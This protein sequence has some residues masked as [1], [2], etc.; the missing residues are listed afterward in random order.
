MK[1]ITPESLYDLI[2]LGDVQLS[3]DGTLAVF[4]RQTVDAATNGYKRNIWIK[5]L[6]SDLPAEPFTSGNK[7]G[8]P[9]FSPDGSRLAF[10]SARGDKAQVYVLQ[11]RGG[12]AHSIVAHSNGVGGF[13]WSPD[14][15][16]IAYTASG[17]ADERAREDGGEAWSVERGASDVAPVGKDPFVAKQEKEKYEHEEQLR[18]DPRTLRRMPYRTG[19]S[20]MEDKWAHIYVSEVPSDFSDDAVAS[21]KPGTPVRVTDGEDS[22]DQPS[23]LRDG[24]A[25]ISAFT[26][27]IEG[28]RWYMYTDV[29]RIEWAKAA[30]APTQRTLTRLTQPGYSCYSPKVSPDGQWIAYE[31]SLEDRPGHR[32]Q[33]IALLPADA[34]TADVEP[35]DL[36]SAL[37][38]SVETVKWHPNSQHIY[39]TLL[40]DGNV[41]LWRV[42][43]SD[44]KIEPLTALNHDI[45]SF[46]VDP[47]GRVVFTAGTAQDPSALYAREVD[48]I[49]HILYK[50]NRKFLEAHEL[51]E[52]ERI[53]YPSDDHVI[54]GWVMKPPNYESGT[55]YSLVVEIHG[56]PH[57]QW[58][59]NFP[60]MF[61]E[62]QTLAHQGYI[63]FFC[64]PRGADGY[65]EAFMGAN[66]KDW[67]PGPT[68][69]VL[70]GVDELI[71]RGDIDVERMAVT[72]GSY[73][74]YLT[75]WI[76]GHD[77]R[78]KAAVSQ[79]GVY[80]LISMR[81]TTDIPFFNDF[82][83]GFTPWENINS[84]WEQSPLAHVPNMHTPLLIEH[85][86]Q[87]YRVPMEQAEQLFQAL[88]LLKKP[89]EFLRWPR[90][91]H[92]L[93]RSGEPRHRVQRLQRM[94]EWFDRYTKQIMSQAS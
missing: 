30:E 53:Q 71:A 77:Q 51:G 91:G 62:W 31:R 10:I 6:Q 90:E 41:N 42:S 73:G 15:K 65:G 69:D 45:T 19:T 85:S 13:E 16:R 94:I 79:R 68:R 43:V 26:R 74:G 80:N 11:M 70:R 54:E 84:L 72:G 76:I 56:G 52:I 82:E 49:V 29:V 37:D 33:S 57:V 89:V 4:V 1:S 61:H 9:R 83:S 81:G 93:S 25:L 27:E 22:F 67:G 44:K 35:I 2:N 12:E 28:P 24:S 3:S 58:T 64:N 47:T 5:D 23:W 40:K 18:F 59:P 60:S 14:G 78:F 34:R 48:G 36:T 86:E 20:F 32:I 38:R 63:V 7:D 88:V 39:F 87:D 92:E 55:K 75:A 66:W 21:D 17:R 46:D 50:P 8:S